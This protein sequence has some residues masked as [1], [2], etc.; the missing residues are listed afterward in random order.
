MG[1]YYGSWEFGNRISHRVYCLDRSGWPSADSPE[2]VER[3]R[4][5]FW[6]QKIVVIGVV[7]EICFQPSRSTGRRLRQ[8]KLWV[9]FRWYSIS[10]A[11]LNGVKGDSHPPPS[12]LGDRVITLYNPNRHWGAPTKYYITGNTLRGWA[13]RGE[14]K[15]LTRFMDYQWM[16]YPNGLHL[17]SFGKPKK[18]LW[19]TLSIL[20]FSLRTYQKTERPQKRGIF[21]IY[22]AFPGI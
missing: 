11:H 17:Q 20:W 2:A 21:K 8:P 22:N 7:S 16:D 12:L 10:W 3:Q 18:N 9:C 15:T 4:S 14:D 1:F 5:I 19:A 6:R 13:A